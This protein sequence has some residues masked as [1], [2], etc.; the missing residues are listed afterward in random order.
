ME[1]VWLFGFASTVIV[2]VLRNVLLV[3]FIHILNNAAVTYFSVVK[4]SNPIGYFITSFFII[5]IFWVYYLFRR[6]GVR[7]V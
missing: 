2:L 6:R 1:K 3:D 7:N 4:V 5:A